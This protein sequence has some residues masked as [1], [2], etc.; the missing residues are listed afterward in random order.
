MPVIAETWTIRCWL[1]MLIIGKPSAKSSGADLEHA[2]ELFV[3]LLLSITGKGILASELT[4][5]F[6]LAW[7]Q[8]YAGRIGGGPRNV[9]GGPG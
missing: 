2:I 7:A 9:P 5:L 3:A 6:L 1:L 8:M 4:A